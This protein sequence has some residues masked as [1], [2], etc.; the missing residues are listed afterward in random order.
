MEQIKK[1][2]AT[3]KLNKKDKK[4]MQNRKSALNCK[5]K[6]VHKEVKMQKKLKKEKEE[7]FVLQMEQENLEAKLRSL[8][9][10]AQELKEAIKEKEKVTL[11][12]VLTYVKGLQ[13]K[14]MDN[15][16]KIFLPL[17]N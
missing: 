4:L 5:L 1:E 3:R 8:R 15:E 7:N 10:K 13:I 9:I 6:E 14:C 2:L 12:F 17:P 16:A 11:D